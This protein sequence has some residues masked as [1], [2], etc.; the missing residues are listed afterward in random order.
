VKPG[1]QRSQLDQTVHY[2]SAGGIIQGVARFP[3]AGLY[4]SV[5]RSMA[6]GSG[7]EVFAILPRLD[8]LEV[9]RLNF[10]KQLAPLVQGAEM[11]QVTISQG[12]P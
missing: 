10:Y 2:I 12:N 8:S 1:D 4:Y 6:V 7:G 3:R 5:R 11:P 9:V